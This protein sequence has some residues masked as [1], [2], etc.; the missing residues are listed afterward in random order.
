MRDTSRAF[1]TNQNLE[2]VR[3]KYSS[4]DETAVPLS[5]KSYWHKY[6]KKNAD[7]SLLLL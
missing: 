5:S 2:V 7:Y 4:Q 1:P 6:T 3:W